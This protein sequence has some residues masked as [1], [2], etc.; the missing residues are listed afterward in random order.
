LS[1]NI[2]Q[3]PASTPQHQATAAAPAIGTAKLPGAS[4]DIG[5][6]KRNA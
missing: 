1:A 2:D 4:L 5:S 6:M 3:L